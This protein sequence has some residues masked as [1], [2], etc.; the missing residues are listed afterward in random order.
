L[1]N[2]VVAGR[3]NHPGLTVMLAGLLAGALDLSF[4]LLFYGHQGATP[5]RI[6]RGIAAGLIGRD[7]ALG[8]GSAPVLLGL[9]LH[10]SIAVCAAFV[11]YRASATFTVLTRR[12]LIS[13][14][15]FGVAVY[16]FMHFIVIPL[17]R[18]PFHLQSLPNALGE[19][20][21]HVFL[22]GIVIALG[23]VRARR[24]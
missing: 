2:T 11:F 15:L 20:C 4:A 16:C 24:A 19:L 5:T 7:A 17:S 21:S 23:V 14:A 18:I 10:F 22:F 13:G 8:A 9:V 3:R 1:E 12:P 6:L